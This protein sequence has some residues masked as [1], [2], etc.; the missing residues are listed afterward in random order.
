MMRVDCHFRDDT[1]QALCD[2]LGDLVQILRDHDVTLDGVRWC[3][4][5]SGDDVWI[6]ASWLDREDYSD[7]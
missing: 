7:G 1:P 3:A 2:A 4:T 5:R 6:R